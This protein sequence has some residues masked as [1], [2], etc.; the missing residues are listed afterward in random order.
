MNVA[1]GVILTRKVTVPEMLY[2]RTVDPTGDNKP[3]HSMEVIISPGI[4]TYLIPAMVTVELSNTTSA[5]MCQGGF[6]TS[7][8]DASANWLTPLSEVKCSCP[9][10]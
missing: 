3:T 4:G 10:K 2:W 7:T 8:I 1:V 9:H 5:A 6:S